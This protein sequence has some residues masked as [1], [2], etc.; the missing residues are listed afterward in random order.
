MTI[1]FLSKISQGRRLS[2]EGRSSQILADDYLGASGDKMTDVDV[3]AQV[4]DIH[5]TGLRGACH[6]RVIG[7]HAVKIV[8]DA[9]DQ[10]RRIEQK[11]QGLLRGTRYIWL[12][13]L[14]RKHHAGFPCPQR[15]GVAGAR[16]RVVTIHAKQRGT[17]FLSFRR[18][19]QAT[20]QTTVL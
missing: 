16:V 17:K 15:A 7:F 4:A 8:N 13:K 12:R 10:V 19:C 5:V 9:V 14:K 11:R 20:L 2:E 3:P 18:H 1:S 6:E